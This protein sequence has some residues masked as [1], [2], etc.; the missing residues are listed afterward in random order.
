MYGYKKMK[1]HSKN[2]LT[3]MQGKTMNITRCLVELVSHET[4]KH[5]LKSS[6]GDQVGDSELLYTKHVY[7][8]AV[9]QESIENISPQLSTD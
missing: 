3:N 4:V 6:C 2:Q 1:Y 5:N 7:T 8:S 9:C